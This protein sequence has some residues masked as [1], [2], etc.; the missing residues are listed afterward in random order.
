MKFPR[1]MG[2]PVRCALPLSM[3]LFASPAMASD[4][5]GFF[6][7]FIGT[8]ALVFCS[9]LLGLLLSCLYIRVNSLAMTYALFCLVC[10]VVPVGWLDAISLPLLFVIRWKMSGDTWFELFLAVLALWLSAQ[11]LLALRVFI[12]SRTPSSALPQGRIA[13][14]MSHAALVTA[15]VIGVLMLIEIGKNTIDKIQNEGASRG[16]HVLILLIPLALLLPLVWK[17]HQLIRKARNPP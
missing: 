12:L 14:T 9:L 10:I 15:A 8:P 11:A 13:S 16:L 4:F 17:L 7:M 5:T 3:L 1:R 2:T 6:S